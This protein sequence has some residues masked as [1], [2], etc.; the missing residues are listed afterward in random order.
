MLTAAFGRAWLDSGRLKIRFRAPA[1]PGDTLT[2]TGHVTKVEDKHVICAVA[3]RTGSAEV[4]VD[5]TAE[6]SLA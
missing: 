5:G 6:V 2:A 1:R 3:C 4:I